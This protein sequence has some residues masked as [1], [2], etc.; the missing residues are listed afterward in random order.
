MN[1]PN[2]YPTCLSRLTRDRRGNAAVEFAFTAVPL[3][4]FLFTIITAG[5]TVWLQNAL[6]ASVAEAARCA[7]VNPTLCGS[8]SQ[9]QA[10]AANHAGAGFEGSIFALA[11]IGCG[12]QVSASYPLAL[13]VPFTA[14][15]VTLSAQACF[16]V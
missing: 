6:N 11:R 4:M 2:R 14:L 9:V 15:S 12:N 3:V 13:T 5:Q 1:R 10:Y 7:T 8:E 16:P